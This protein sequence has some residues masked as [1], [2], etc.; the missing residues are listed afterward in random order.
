[1]ERIKSVGNAAILLELAKRV[2]NVRATETRSESMNL[3][4]MTRIGNL[5]EVVQS[6]EEE[7]A[8]NS[9]EANKLLDRESERV[10][11][12]R[13]DDDLMEMDE[14]AGRVEVMNGACNDRD[15]TFWKL[16]CQSTLKQLVVGDE[17]LQYVKE[18]KLEGFVKL[19]KVEIGEKCFCLGSECVF[20]VRECE[21]LESVRI[22]DG[23]FVDVVSVVFEGELKWN[24]MR[25]RF[26]SVEIDCAGEGCV[27][28]R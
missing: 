16:S 6:D 14:E 20:E 13:S 7:K 5:N 26:E 15:I 12:I 27:Q 24:G 2:G 17:C 11:V 22:G 9:G 25:S 10:M 3:M 4:P 23:S 19:E 21:K 18:L 1:M 8:G 28:R